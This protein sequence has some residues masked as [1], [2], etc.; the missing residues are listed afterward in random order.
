MLTVLQVTLV[1]VRK[2][3]MGWPGVVVS[4]RM[5]EIEQVRYCYDMAAAG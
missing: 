3:A 5:H 2:E 4:W 1:H